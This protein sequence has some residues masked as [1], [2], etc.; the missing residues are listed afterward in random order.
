[1]P[2]VA[3]MTLK[4]LIISLMGNILVKSQGFELLQA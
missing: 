1:M 3:M 4:W 2:K